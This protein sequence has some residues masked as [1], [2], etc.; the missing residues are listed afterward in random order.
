[1][2]LAGASNAAGD[3]DN[4]YPVLSLEQILNMQPEIIIDAS[5]GDAHGAHQNAANFW[6]RWP[7]LE[8]VRSGRVFVF[9]STLWLRTG[10]RLPQGL[11]K[12]MELVHPQLKR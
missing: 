9:D 6:K 10:P 7:Q 3:I 11:E 12:L 4:R 8:A 2:E 5:A 1:L